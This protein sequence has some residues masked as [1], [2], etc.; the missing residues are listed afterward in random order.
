MFKTSVKIHIGK[1][2]VNIIVFVGNVADDCIL[3]SEFFDKVGVSNLIYKLF[4][5]A[6]SSINNICNVAFA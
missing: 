6:P 1:Y 5:D 3:G 4:V 2:S